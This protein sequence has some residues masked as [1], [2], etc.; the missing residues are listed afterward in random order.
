MTAQISAQIFT[1]LKV[2]LG[3]IRCSTC[4]K[5]TPRRDQTV[6]EWV[7]EMGVVRSHVQRRKLPRRSQ[8]ATTSVKYKITSG[9]STEASGRSAEQRSHAFGS[10]RL[11]GQAARMGLARYSNLSGSR[12]QR[13]YLI[14]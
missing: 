2:F 8:A 9:I 1:Y 7:I 3:N 6:K 12:F 14:Q 10:R 5:I 4:S 11:L 13:L